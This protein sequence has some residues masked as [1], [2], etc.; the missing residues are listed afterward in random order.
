V[1]G[2]KNGKSGRAGSGNFSIL[3][4]EFR[5]GIKGERE[6]RKEVDSQTP[7]AQSLGELPVVMEAWSCF[8]KKNKNSEEKRKHK[9]FPT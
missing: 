3:E 6:H 9:G 7:R 1:Q 5:A 2:E 4:I 8:I